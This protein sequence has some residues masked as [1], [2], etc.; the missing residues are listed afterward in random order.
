MFISVS[1]KALGFR[2]TGPIPALVCLVAS[3]VIHWTLLAAR[4][5]FFTLTQTQSIVVGT[6]HA[7]VIVIILFFCM[8]AQQ[9]DTAQGAVLNVPRKVTYGKYDWEGETHVMNV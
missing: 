6:T 9:T 4:G 1:G 7:V 5:P 3:W 8:V 2:I